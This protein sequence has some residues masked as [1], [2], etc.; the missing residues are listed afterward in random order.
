MGAGAG[1]GDHAVHPDHPNAPPPAAAGNNDRLTVFYDL[2]GG[3]NRWLGVAALIFA[4]SPA[5]KFNLR[6]PDATSD[7]AQAL[8]R[9][10]ERRYA[11]MGR[12]YVCVTGSA[13]IYR[14]KPEIELTQFGQL[15]DTP[16]GG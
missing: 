8:L 13:K 6:I 1:L 5:H 4:G 14:G 15:S 10:I 7:E 9:L 3:I 2:Q 11:G 16:P 12:G